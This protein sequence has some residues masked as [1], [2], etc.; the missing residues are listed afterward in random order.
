VEVRKP[1]GWLFGDLGRPFLE[2]TAFSLVL[3]ELPGSVAANLHR[4]IKRNHKLGPA[5]STKA[6]LKNR[7]KLRAE[8]SS[9]FSESN[10]LHDGELESIT[11]K[12]TFFGI[13]NEVLLKELPWLP[14]TWDQFS[15]LGLSP[16]NSVFDLAGLT[17]GELA[18]VSD[19]NWDVVFDVYQMIFSWLESAL[20]YPVRISSSDSLAVEIEKFER[21]I[22]LRAGLTGVPSMKWADLLSIRLGWGQERKTLEEI[23]SVWGLSRE[24]V[25][26]IE[27]Q[28]LR[29]AQSRPQVSSAKIR[30]L[31]DLDYERTELDSMTVIRKEFEL[32]DEWS[33]H[34]LANYIDLGVSADASSMFQAATGKSSPR[35]D[36]DIVLAQAI[37]KAR[38]KLGVIKTDTIILPGLATPIDK[39]VV[40]DQI[41]LV[42]GFTL[43]SGN[44][45]VVSGKANTPSIL[46]VISKQLAVA[47]KLHVDQL[48]EGIRRKASQVQAQHALPPT[49]DLVSMLRQ[50]GLFEVD[51]QSIVSGRTEVTPPENAD[52]WL[53][54]RV[55]TAKGRVIS[56]AQIMRLAM[57]ENHKI[58]TISIY[59]SFSPLIRYAG[60][61][62]LTVVGASPSAQDI[63]YATSVAEAGNIPN[64]IL[65]YRVDPE[66]QELVIRF[67]YSTPFLIN[68]ILPVSRLLGGLIG[69]DKRAI[70]CCE[71]FSTSASAKLA[72]G[73]MILGFA[74]VREHVFDE[75]GVREGDTLTIIIREGTVSFSW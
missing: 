45:A 43:F 23:A 20:Q 61:G 21:S 64:E 54:N 46:T 60:E 2:E 55:N 72:S 56:K 1:G 48:Q 47:P 8:V 38:T 6:M 33:L 3:S 17:W 26:Q 30:R 7:E 58:S 5:I 28:L 51:E 35:R 32:S 65:N 16:E 62:L 25:R 29:I 31:I 44:F 40:L 37:R 18:G 11:F 39:Q 13:E 22:I 70:F 9:L 67:V 59:I 41:P 71:T 74:P 10:K 57:A 24:R 66:T 15:A 14:G 49:E 63:E 42:Y 34:G 73:S 69:P 19:P 4:L 52:G 27:S 12:S 75:H 68:G 50:S 36:K 53:L